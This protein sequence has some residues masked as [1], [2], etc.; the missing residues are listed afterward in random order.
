[1]FGEFDSEVLHSGKLQPYTQ[2]LD[3]FDIRVFRYKG[4]SLFSFINEEN[5][6]P[7]YICHQG[8]LAE[9]EGSVQLTS[10]LRQLVCYKG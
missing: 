10:S 4:L 7:G 9:R 6:R 8:T 1:M 5:T 3:K 2:R